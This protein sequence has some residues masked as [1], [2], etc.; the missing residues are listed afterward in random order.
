MDAS[1]I[2]MTRHPSS[3]VKIAQLSSQHGAT[4]F[5]DALTR[6]IV[7]QN[8]PLMT[9]AEI[10]RASASVYLPFS[11]IPVYHKIKVWVQDPHD[12][13][14]P[15]SKTRDVIHVRPARLDKYSNSIPARFDTALV[16]THTNNTSS[17]GDRYGLERE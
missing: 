1:R 9:P 17:T 8:H 14:A 13:A 4:F 11:S 7:S 10:E 12:V 3:N 16:R 15:D 5:R 6:F 2:E